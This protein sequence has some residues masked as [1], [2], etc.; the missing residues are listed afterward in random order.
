MELEVSPSLW[1]QA[2][3]QYKGKLLLS[4][5]DVVTLR[6]FHHV[7]PLFYQIMRHLA[8]NFKLFL[9]YRMLRFR[10]SLNL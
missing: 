8:L 6:T 7:L 3:S 10:K 1:L 2:V 9:M 4:F 5:S